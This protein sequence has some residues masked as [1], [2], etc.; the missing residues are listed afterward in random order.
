ML[1]NDLQCGKVYW[2]PTCGVPLLTIVDE[3]PKCNICESKKDKPGYAASDMRPVFGPERDLLESKLRIRIPYNIFYNRRR[4]IYQGQTL[5]FFTLR[6]GEIV[7]RKENPANCA[8]QED[9]DKGDYE[10]YLKKVVKAN[11]TILNRLEQEAIKFIKKKTEQYPGRRHFVSFS[12]GKDSTVVANLVQEA[13]GDVSLFF[14]DTTL[15]YEETTQYVRNFAENY[16]LPLETRA[17]PNDFFEM[18]EKLGPPSRILRWCCSVFKAYPINLFWGSLD[19]YV[20]GFDGLRK[21]ESRR[22][23]EYPRIFQSEKFA[24][25]VAARPILNWSSLAVWLYIY[26]KDLLFNPLYKRGY[27]RLG[28]FLCPYNTNYDDY[29]NSYYQIPRWQQWLNFLEDY[30]KKE[31]VHRSKEWIDGWV[32]QEYWK[33][34]RP[35]KRT[36]YVVSKNSDGGTALLYIFE[37]GIPPNLPEFLKPI[38]SIETSSSGCDEFA[39]RSCQQSQT[40]VVGRVGDKLLRISISEE[41]QPKEFQ[42]LVERQ[43]EKAVNCVGCGGCI[44]ICPHKAISLDNGSI[45]INNEIC[46]HENCRLCVTTDIGGSGYSCIAM[47]YKA[48]RRRITRNGKEVGVSRLQA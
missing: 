33:Q 30:A 9:L 17:S 12:G 2:C 11:T 34:R 39:F 4:I 28:C 10:E 7:L 26:Y 24:R 37:N 32:H 21:A 19:D 5:F 44:G 14:A 38:C 46:R 16:L 13:L 1:D 22:R 3:E 23:S 41:E 35:R 29:L 25:Q 45:T 27:A 48:F 20:L 36:E 6:D 15:E 18:S 42:R 47:S 31:Y 40:R 43:I 8:S